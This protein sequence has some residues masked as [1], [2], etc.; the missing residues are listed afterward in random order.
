MGAIF[1]FGEL[2]ILFSI[3]YISHY[4]VNNIA[5]QKFLFSTPSSAFAISCIFDKWYLKTFE[6]L[7]HC[8]F[9]LHFSDAKVLV[10]FLSNYC[11]FV[12]ISE[13]IYFGFVHRKIDLFP[14]LDFLIVV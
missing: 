13:K 1:Y 3:V 6:V 11:L 5:K 14:E 7:S 2:S 10:T 4:I 9:D 12:Y 8:R